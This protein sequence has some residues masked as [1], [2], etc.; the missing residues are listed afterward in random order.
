MTSTVLYPAAWTGA[1][2][3]KNVTSIST[4][5]GICVVLRREIPLKVYLSSRKSSSW[6]RGSMSEAEI[7]QGT[8][9]QSLLSCHVNPVEEQ[10][11]RQSKPRYIYRHCVNMY[12]E[13]DSHPKGYMTIGLFPVLKLTELLKA[14]FVSICRWSAFLFGPPTC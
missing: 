14:H 9:V 8:L 12:K 3:C 2:S 6:L 4:L 11:C 5:R 13:A 7:L 10:T 1:C